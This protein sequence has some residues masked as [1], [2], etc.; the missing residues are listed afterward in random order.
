MEPI[1]SKFE[2]HAWKTQTAMNT[3]KLKKS[4]GSSQVRG[5]WIFVLQL[6]LGKLHLLNHEK[7][8]DITNENFILK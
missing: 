1:K 3:K 5:S 8:D 4:R 7:G 6:D 2:S